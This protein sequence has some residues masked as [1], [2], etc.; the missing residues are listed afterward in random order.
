MQS[1]EICYTSNAAKPIFIIWVQPKNEFSYICFNI[2][3]IYCANTPLIYS[4]PVT[5]IVV[6]YVCLM[7]TY[8]SVMRTGFSVFLGQSNYIFACKIMQKMLRVRVMLWPCKI[9]LSPPVVLY[10]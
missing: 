9:D 1:I 6:I 8:S 2:L 7:D 4:R 3:E 5:Y 10:Y